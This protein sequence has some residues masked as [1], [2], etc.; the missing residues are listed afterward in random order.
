MYILIDRDGV[1]NQKNKNHF[2][3]RNLQLNY[4]Y[5]SEK[6][7]HEQIAIDYIYDYDIPVGGGA[8]DFFLS[9]YP[10]TKTTLNE[11]EQGNELLA[12]TLIVSPNTSGQYVQ[13]DNIDYYNSAGSL[14]T[15]P[16]FLRRVPDYDTTP[17]FEN[18]LDDGEFTITVVGDIGVN[19]HFDK[20]YEIE[21][22][23]GYM[24]EIVLVGTSWGKFSKNNLM[25]S[26]PLCG[27][28]KDTN[29]AVEEMIRAF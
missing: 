21:F 29:P 10:K 3:V 18:E 22:F 2:Y 5:K 13:L 12:E 16:S 11:L 14:V 4:G 25:P 19:I 24:Q 17:I 1:L 15:R 28:I 26:N 23:I 7:T 27:Y 8:T 6:L 9:L 20:N